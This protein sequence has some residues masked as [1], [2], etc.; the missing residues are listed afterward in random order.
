MAS[1]SLSVPK[2]M[3]SKYNEITE[4][5]SGFCEKHLNDEYGEGINKCYQIIYDQESGI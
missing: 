1:K 3:Q 5:I 2:K 4:V